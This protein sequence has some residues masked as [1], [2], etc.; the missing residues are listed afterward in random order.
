MQD[1]G[2]GAL[3]GTAAPA[4]SSASGLRDQRP[5]ASGAT[6]GDRRRRVR[7]RRG[8]PDGGGRPRGRD[9]GELSALGVAGGRADG[10]GASKGQGPGLPGPGSPPG[11]RP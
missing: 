7:G 1:G 6:G 10:R 11:D 9:P 8:G 4:G 5:R 2:G 3:R